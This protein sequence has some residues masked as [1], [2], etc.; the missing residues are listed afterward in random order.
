LPDDRFLAIFHDITDR[1]DAQEALLRSQAES[2]SHLRT[3]EQRFRDIS[4]ATGEFIWEVDAQGLYI[5]ASRACKTLLGYTEDEIVGRLHFY[6]LHPQPGRSEFR[7]KAF[8]IF[9]QRTAF[10]DFHNFVLTKNGQVLDV[11]TN[12]VPIVSGDGRLLGYRGSD[13]DITD[14]KRAER[15]LRE[16]EQRLKNILNSPLVGMGIGDLSGGIK[17]V[18]DT[19]VQLTGYTREDLLAGTVS[20]T[21]FN[22]AE[23][24][25]HDRRCFDELISTGRF[26][27]YEREFIRKDGTR[28]PTLIGGS[29]LPGPSNELAV[30]IIDITDRK[31]AE[32]EKLEMERRL[33]HAQKLESLGLLA[34][35]I[36]HDFNNILA[37]IMGYA[38]L[39][40]LRLSPSEPARADVDV[41][42]SAVHK[43]A[44]LTRQMLA[45]SG[46]GKFVVEAVNLSRLVED[47]RKILEISVSKKAT[48]KFN[49]AD[50]LPAIQGDAS[51][52]H[53]VILNLVINAS[54]ALGDS[55]GVIAVSTDAFRPTE[56][57]RRVFAGGEFGDGP[58]V[59]LE[60]ADS[61]CGMDA[62]SLAKVFDPFFTTKFTGRGLGLAAVHGIVRGHKGAIHVASEP[63]RGTT[64]Q[65]VL[66]AGGS[67]S[68]AA[69]T[70][71][72]AAPWRGAGTVLVADDEE[73]VRNL[74]A[75]MV[76]FA[77]FSAL[78]AGDGEEA[79]RL[80]GEHQDRIVCV[81]LDLNMPEMNG[82]EVFREIRRIAPD[83][84]G[85]L[86]S[87][88]SEKGAT[89]R[90]SG[91][92][93][94][95]FIQKPYQFDS[96][97]SALRLAVTGAAPPEETVSAARPPL[98]GA[99]GAPAN[100]APAAECARPGARTVL[101]VD[102]DQLGRL[103]THAMIEQAGFSVL[104][105]V[106][107]EEAIRVFEA[108]RDQI[109]GVVLDLT[110]PRMSGDETFRAL[111]RLNPAVRII[112]TSGHSAETLAQRFAGLDVFG[113]VCKPAPLDSVIAKL[114]TA[115]A[116]D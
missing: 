75:R 10:V 111:R 3:S 91:L 18:N 67:P 90:F 27:P 56:A 45:Y 113:F 38:D 97:L 29:L 73:I 99:A 43:A 34:G 77:G 84:R 59:R 108:N 50:D 106:D 24:A 86:S 13:R 54:E 21:Q 57:D 36:A 16:S 33:L 116:G 39:V 72:A 19:L 23:Y 112:V 35:G 104:T 40:R 82:A 88:Y 115:C 114:K 32:W 2:E 62:E 100:L 5:Y 103:S 65:I 15:A 61:G 53:Q 22:P 1:K 49:L 51:Q 42:I 79:L 58:C 87:G 71:S 74:A 4:E 63:G 52:M 68:P 109:V 78:T 12:G 105:A 98:G 28:V 85:I 70:V 46:K 6:D 66:P 20:W 81:L 93:L 101:L 64:F 37:G 47:M 17:E 41:I 89:E 96:L 95:G 92:G 11:L 55:S 80:F 83:M 102:D 7:R 26:G 44:E 8:D 30:F 107:G 31:R 9:A 48:L 76:E 14:R 69:A 110:L 60:V 25:D 94:A